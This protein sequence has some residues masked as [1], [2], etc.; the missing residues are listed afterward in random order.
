M[1]ITAL[2]IFVIPAQAGTY[3]KVQTSGHP[4]L[5]ANSVSCRGFRPS[6]E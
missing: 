1:T 4:E 6:P 3:D 2:P 5:G